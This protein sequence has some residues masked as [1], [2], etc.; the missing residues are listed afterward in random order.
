MFRRTRPT[1]APAVRIAARPTIELRVRPE[2]LPAEITSRERG[3]AVD[4]A[5]LITERHG[6][7]DD[8]IRYATFMLRWLEDATSAA[9]LEVRALAVHKWR[10]ANLTGRRG[11]DIGVALAEIDD[12]HE[13]LDGRLPAVI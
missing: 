11:E 10:S 13:F 6:S 4:A 5:D 8:R 2:D 9:D 1:T 3:L 7:P 12:L